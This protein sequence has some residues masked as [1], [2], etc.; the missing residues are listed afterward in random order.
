MRK[1]SSMHLEAVEEYLLFTALKVFYR[2]SI[3]NAQENSS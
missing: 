2:W 3:P 1:P